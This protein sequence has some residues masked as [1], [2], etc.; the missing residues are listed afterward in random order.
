MDPETGRRRSRWAV[1]ALVSIGV[2]ST[3]AATTAAGVDIAAHNA[4]A[5]T[6]APSTPTDIPNTGPAP[7]L[8]DIPSAPQLLPGSGY[9]HT[10]SGGS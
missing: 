3:V 5:S 10:R 4:A 2:L 1:R 8:Q 7:T 9:S 6:P